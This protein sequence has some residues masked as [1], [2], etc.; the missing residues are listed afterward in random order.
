MQ[1]GHT[2]PRPGSR[3]EAGS[4]GEVFGFDALAPPEGTLLGGS[5]QRV[6]GTPLF[7]HGRV[8][9]RL[10]GLRPTRDHQEPSCAY[11]ADPPAE[12]LMGSSNRLGED[13]IGWTGRE[14]LDST[15]SRFEIL[16]TQLTPDG[17]LKMVT[18]L[19]A[20]NQKHRKVGAG[21][22]D[23]DTGKTRP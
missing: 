5:R 13:E 10:G 2:P 19:A 16:Q 3:P 15:E 20:F 1:P 22:R 14:G 17:T 6:A 18:P 23:G 9:T 4:L 7:A 21:D 8:E 11:P 12:N